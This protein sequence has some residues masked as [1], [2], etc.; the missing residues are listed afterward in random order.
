LNPYRALEAAQAVN[1]KRAEN[2]LLYPSKPWETKEQYE[3]AVQ[4]Y[5]F[6]SEK[7]KLLGDTVNKAEED[8]IQYKLQRGKEL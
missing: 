6:Q 3:A 8:M 2:Q 4:E 5:K 1:Y 7:S